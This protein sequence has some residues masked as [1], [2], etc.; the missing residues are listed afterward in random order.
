[1]H[2]SEKTSGKLMLS[3]DSVCVVKIIGESVS[4]SMSLH[5]IV[6]PRPPE[7]SCNNHNKIVYAK[8]VVSAVESKPAPWK[9][10][11]QYQ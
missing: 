11:G 1:M 2:S 4:A 8:I 9:H 5:G 7:T 10:R 6:I 3:P